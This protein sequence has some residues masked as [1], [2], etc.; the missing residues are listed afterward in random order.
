VVVENE[1]EWVLEADLPAEKAKN[2]QVVAYDI[3]LHFSSLT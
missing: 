2:K 1:G 3:E